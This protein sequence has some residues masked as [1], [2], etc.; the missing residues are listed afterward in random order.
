ML[1]LVALCGLWG[2]TSLKQGCTASA[3]F[4]PSMNTLFQRFSS[5]F[6]QSQDILGKDQFDTPVDFNKLPSNYHHEENKQQTVG[7][8]TFF[9]HYEISKMT[10]NNTGDMMFSEKSLTSIDQKEIYPVE[11]DN[12]STSNEE[13]NSPEPEKTTAGIKILKLGFPQ[14]QPKLTFYIFRLPQHLKSQQMPEAKVVKEEPIS[15]KRHR[16]LAIRNGLLAAPHP[17]KETLPVVPN[18]KA[19]P[20]KRSFVFFWRK[21]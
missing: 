15:D 2:L 14:L 16:L 10:D 13:D 21:I 9:R 17:T 4:L 20:R 12:K 3:I 6:E 19:I 11:E 18:H 5:L 8:S 7:N 1:L